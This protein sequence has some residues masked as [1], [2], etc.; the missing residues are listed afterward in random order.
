MIFEFVVFEDFI[1]CKVYCKEKDF[2]V[3]KVYVIRDINR[4]FDV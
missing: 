2:I 1:V 4:F 3:L